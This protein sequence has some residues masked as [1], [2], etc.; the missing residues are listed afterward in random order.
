MRICHLDN[1]GK[2]AIDVCIVLVKPRN[3]FAADFVQSAVARK[4][5]SAVRLPHNANALIAQGEGFLD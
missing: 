5:H 2:C 3:P 4:G 1:L